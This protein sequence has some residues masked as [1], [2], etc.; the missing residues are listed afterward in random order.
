[1]LLGLGL[2]GAG[3]LRLLLGGEARLLGLVREDEQLLERSLA[4]FEALR[5][6]THA[7]ETRAVLA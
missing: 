4:A 5:L 6:E 3:A 7:A 1:M 2:A